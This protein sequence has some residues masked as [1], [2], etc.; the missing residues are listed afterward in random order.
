MSTKITVSELNEHI[1]NNI[2]DNVIYKIVG[3]INNI[4]FSGH[5]IYFSIRDG[6]SEINSIIWK[7]DNYETVLS[8]NIE[9][10]FDGRLEYYVKMGRINFIITNF[11]IIKKK[12]NELTLLRRKFKDEGLVK[13][14]LTIIN[15]KINILGII[16]S[17]NGA[18]MND[19]LV[20]LKKN[21]FK[22]MVIIKNCL[23]QGN[24]SAQSIMDSIDWFYNNM[25]VDALV[26]ARGGGSESDLNSYSDEKLCKKVSSCRYTT[27]SA[28]GHERDSVL[29]D[30]VCDI[31]ASTPTMAGELISKE[32]LDY[33]KNIN[34]IENRIEL[35]KGKIQ[36]N[37]EMYRKTNNKYKK[38]MKNPDEEIK[39]MNDKLNKI[40]N[41]ILRNILTYKS[42]VEKYNKPK[43]MTYLKCNNKI[44]TTL[45]EYNKFKKSGKEIKIHFIDG[46]ISI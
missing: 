30:Y 26:I 36:K 46:V 13:Q 45:V 39:N 6:K 29:L 43:I 9:Y 18:A 35:L 14:Q 33:D 4:K 5:S 10:E 32:Y 16:T 15:K 37:I 2:K 28:V 24:N 34:I 7:Y 42:K 40:K 17:I 27:V 20:V 41:N 44:I 11:I 3:T 23:V 21:N 38:N 19:M 31:R 22:G 8:D 1:R 12:E 25:Y